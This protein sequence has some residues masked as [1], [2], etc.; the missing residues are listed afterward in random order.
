MSTLSHVHCD[1]CGWTGTE[2]DL[3]NSQGGPAC[4][5]CGADVRI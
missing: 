1:D 3:D 5:D 2:S 4:P